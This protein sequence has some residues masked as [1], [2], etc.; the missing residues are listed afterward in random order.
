MIARKEIVVGSGPD[1]FRADER[2]RF[3]DA[4]LRWLAESF[5]Q[6]H[7]TLAVLPEGVTI[8]Y[9]ARLANP[10]PYVNFMPPEL[11]LFGERDIVAAFDAH[12]PDVVLLVHKSTAEYGYPFFGRDYATELGRWLTENYRPATDRD[13]K[14]LLM[15]DPPLQPG[16][17][18]GMAVLVPR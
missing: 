6:K 7:P 2:G 11:V 13:G 14:A 5:P 12:P 8:N 3:V 15:G 17:R 9:L 4:M 1:A 16:S 10:T 18:F